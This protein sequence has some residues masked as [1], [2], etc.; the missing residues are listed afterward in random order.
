[1]ELP[2]IAELKTYVEQKFGRKPHS[3]NDFDELT[4][5]INRKVED[6]ISASTLKRIWGY[7]A[8]KR[9]MRHYT[10]NTLAQY[11][12]YSDF[13]TFVNYLKTSTKYNSSFFNAMQ[14]HSNELKAGQHLQIGWSP[15]RLLTLE[16]LGDSEYEVQ[17]AENSKL[18]KGDRFVTGCFIMEQ[19]LYLPFIERNGEHT[20]PFVA[21]RNGGLTV[22]NITD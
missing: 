9:K 17:E 22:I 19:P 13:D 2:E 11:I 21:G 20:T 16:Y 15:N 18:M 6:G 10:L 8:D 5:A 3:T 14:I 7:V 4:L 12:G 1:M